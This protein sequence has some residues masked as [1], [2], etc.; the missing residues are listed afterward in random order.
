[1]NGKLI[2]KYSVHGDI[3]T[4]KGLYYIKSIRIIIYIKV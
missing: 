4:T 3:T 1:M 2:I